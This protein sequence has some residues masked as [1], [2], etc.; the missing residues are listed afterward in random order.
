[1]KETN[2]TWKPITTDHKKQFPGN[3]FLWMAG[4]HQ[5]KEVISPWASIQISS[6]HKTKL[7]LFL[8]L[9]AQPRVQSWGYGEGHNDDYLSEFCRIALFYERGLYCIY[10]C[11]SIKR[12]P[13]H[14]IVAYIF[15][16]C[17]GRYFWRRLAFE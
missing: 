16:V 5:E 9:S 15:W 17:L 11:P 10:A 1:M 14:T 8:L 6:F 13:L 7:S 4:R 2:V 12:R 3:V